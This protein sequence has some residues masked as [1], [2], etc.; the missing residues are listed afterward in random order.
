ML[1]KR[2]SLLRQEVLGLDILCVLAAYFLS[3]VI[4][5]GILTAQMFSSLYGST[6]FV[7]ILSY[8]A[9]YMFR[10]EKAEDIFKRGMWEEFLQVFRDQVKVGLI[11]LLYLFVTQRGTFYSRF[12]FGVFFLLS[13]LFIYIVRNYFKLLMMTAYRNSS[14]SRKVLLM[15]DL[16]HVPECVRNFRGAGL[17]DMKVESICVLDKDMEGQEILGIPVVANLNDVMEKVQ[18]GMVDH[19]FI[20]IPIEWA[21]SILLEPIILYF[22]KMGLTVHVAL[23]V[24]SHMDVENKKISNLAGMQVVSFFSNLYNSRLM[25]MKRLC[26]LVGSVVGLMITAVLVVFLAPAIYLEDPGPIFFSQ[27]RVGKNGRRFKI[28]KFRSMVM[29]AEKLKKNLM[30]QNEMEGLMFKMENDPR[31]TKVGRFIRKTSLDEFP[32]FWNVLKGDMSLVGTRPPTLDEFEQYTPEYRRRLSIRPGITGLWQIS[33]RS[34]II[35]FDEVVK[36]DLE[37]IDQ[38]SLKKDIWILC[39]TVGIVLFGKGAK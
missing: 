22:E 3:A 31:V 37:Y 24:F 34:D 11:L 9:I 27:V 5:K 26:D 10:E 32:Q 29:D 7:L 19:I 1:T 38:W 23:N 21:D 25:F 30:S 28:Y 16:A 6:L 39:K 14:F 35:E 13:T 36:L 20:K 18:Y 15:T 8:V 2:K 33:G 12:F 4:R 17:W